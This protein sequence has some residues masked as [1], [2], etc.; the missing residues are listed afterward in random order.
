MGPGLEGRIPTIADP[1]AGV[2]LD[3]DLTGGSLARRDGSVGWTV[4]EEVVGGSTTG[5]RTTTRSKRPLDVRERSRS[6][7]TFAEVSS[8]Q[9]GPWD[10]LRLGMYSIAIC[11]TL[12]PT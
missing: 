1:A 8:N 5:S 9:S 7:E 11:G 3:S 10:I 12:Q 4:P 2:A 6:H